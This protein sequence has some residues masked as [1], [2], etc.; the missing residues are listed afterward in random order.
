[1][2]GKISSEMP[3]L[4]MHPPHAFEITAPSWGLAIPRIQVL[5]HPNLRS[6]GIADP[7]NGEPKGC[8]EK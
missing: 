2:A 5:N 4:D 1:L 8:T 6:L 7:V 3:I